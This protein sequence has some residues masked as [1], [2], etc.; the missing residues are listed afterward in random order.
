MRKQIAV[1]VLLISTLTMAAP[2]LGSTTEV[3]RPATTATTIVGYLGGRRQY[4]GTSSFLFRQP[5]ARPVRQPAGRQRST[6]DLAL[7]QRG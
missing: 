6:D 1:M 7:D 5:Q 4:S 3:T 2:A